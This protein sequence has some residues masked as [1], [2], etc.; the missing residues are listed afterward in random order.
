MIEATIYW[1][2]EKLQVVPVGKVRWDVETGRWDYRAKDERVLQDLNKA[3]KMETIPYRSSIEYGDN[4]LEIADEVDSKNPLF[5]DALADWAADN[6]D[7]I[8]DI[9]RD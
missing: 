9:R 7:W 6:S 4:I 5:L 3:K 1:E 2:D 8:R